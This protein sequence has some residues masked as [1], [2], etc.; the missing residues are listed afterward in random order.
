MTD[1]RCGATAFYFISLLKDNHLLLI[2]LFTDN[3]EFFFF[4]LFVC[5]LADAEGMIAS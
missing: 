2:K 1:A 4:L 3:G 5:V